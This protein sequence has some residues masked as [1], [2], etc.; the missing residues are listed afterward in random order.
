[1]R[2]EQH[3]DIAAPAQ[4]VWE[5]IGPA[6]A[7][8]GSWAS[9]IARSGT[10]PGDGGRV[11]EVQGPRASAVTERLTA[12]DDEARTLTYTAAG[13]LPAPLA[14]AR[15]TWAVQAMGSGRSRASMS[16]DVLLSRRWRM[17]APALG[18]ALRLVGRRTLRDLRHRV[19][20]G[21]PTGRK[22]RQVARSSRQAP[23]GGAQADA[24]GLL[25]SAMRINALFSATS[26]VILLLGASA[27]AIRFG[28]PAWI[29]VA[30]GAG[31]LSFSV[32]LLWSLTDA[33]RLTVGGR[34]AVGGDTAWTAGAAVLLT[35]P[36]GGLTAQ[37]RTTLALVTVAVAV[38][39]MLQ[40]VGLWRIRERSA[41]TSGVSSRSLP[42]THEVPPREGSRRGRRPAGGRRGGFA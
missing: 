15:N 19:Q 7:D 37:G 1:M 5:V 17:A 18:L 32:L 42:T 27:L 38:L 25:T 10:A 36:V 31:L 3:I 23:G 6:F 24:G 2:I 16:A 12:Y 26:G 8:I 39:G 41:G 22:R 29:L 40:A 4:Q 21:V 35:T 28:A 14:A 13:G 11:C 20:T 33:R 30:L 9:A 34:V